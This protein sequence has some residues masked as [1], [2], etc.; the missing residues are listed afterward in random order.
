[1]PSSQDGQPGNGLGPQRH[2]GSV[3]RFC[4]RQPRLNLHGV[5]T[6]SR[7]L[8]RLVRL[9]V[10]KPRKRQASER[11]DIASTSQFEGRKR[12]SSASSSDG[13]LRK[14]R[15]GTSQLSQSNI[16]HDDNAAKR[17][18]AEPT[19]TIRGREPIAAS[20]QHLSETTG[21]VESEPN[22]ILA[23]PSS[24]VG[25][26]LSA[27]DV[28]SAPAK[29]LGSAASESSNIDSSHNDSS[30]DAPNNNSSSNNSGEDDVSGVTID[31]DSGGHRS[32]G[33]GKASGSESNSDD[34]DSD[35]TPPRGLNGSPI[36]NRLH[37]E[38][39]EPTE[40]VATTIDQ[41]DSGGLL[42]RGTST[43]G[44]DKQT[45]TPNADNIRGR[46]GCSDDRAGR[47]SGGCANR[48]NS[49]EGNN[50]GSG[51]GS[52]SSSSSSDGSDSEDEDDFDSDVKVSRTGDNGNAGSENEVNNNQQ[53]TA[54]STSQ[55]DGANKS[56]VRR[57][58]T[59]A[60]KVAV[61]HSVQPVA[62]E[63]SLKG[64]GVS[65]AS[66]DS[67]HS[68]TSRLN[69]DNQAEKDEVK[70][71]VKQVLFLSPALSLD[72]AL[73]LA[74]K[75]NVPDVDQDVAGQQQIAKQLF[76]NTPVVASRYSC[77]ETAA[78]HSKSTSKTC[79]AVENSASSTD[80]DSGLTSKRQQESGDKDHDADN[81][82]RGCHGSGSSSGTDSDSE[83]GSESGSGSG[84]GSGSD[85]DSDNDSNSDSDSG[86]GS[87]RDSGRDSGSG[88]DARTES[89]KRTASLPSVHVAGSAAP[90][91]ASAGN[92]TVGSMS[93]KKNGG[94]LGFTDTPSFQPSLTP[95]KLIALSFKS[96]QA[97]TAA[98]TDA[99]TTAKTNKS[100]S[101][102]AFLETSGSNAKTPVFAVKAATNRPSTAAPAGTGSEFKFSAPVAQ[103]T[104]KKRKK[105]AGVL[106]LG[107]L[108]R[109]MK[110]RT[111]SVQKRAV[112]ATNRGGTI[113]SFHD[114][115]SSMRVS[116]G[117][118]LGSDGDLLG[119]IDVPRLGR[120]RSRSDSM[121]SV[122]SV[123]GMYSNTYKNAGSQPNTLAEM[124]SSTN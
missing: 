78:G 15:N 4:F 29:R 22:A 117:A 77:D 66:E 58:S 107:A 5:A 38:S 51:S 35:G 34:Y 71:V 25:N 96:L 112:H 18:S 47:S 48:S 116:M 105:T 103:T 108:C 93:L 115:G 122:S 23:A 20:V 13:G 123:Q 94:Q 91:S 98:T 12:K 39:L 100:P 55:S 86:S 67:S 6:K 49:G 111:G 14:R 45:P 27:A 21:F 70:D 11:H 87:G 1:M 84:S 121:S 2:A 124:L 37:L 42:D 85:S 68:D 64:D 32:G 9:S 69:S 110:K 63:S 99:K 101:M 28:H 102:S 40:D 56:H 44:K 81:R 118:D 109:H 83:S 54:V 31:D 62:A 95:A 113:S 17:R 43:A 10:F 50:S 61:E 59:A 60:T 73:D 114:G 36:N 24:D 75:G 72:D 97:A 120:G 46:N 7:A 104:V 53:P 16:N 30:I 65:S 19:Q 90:D 52:S 79:D 80:A 26:L 89:K 88:S 92:E 82:S 106:S 74:S 57:N 76:P 33:S 119:R 8:Q 3:R 41:R